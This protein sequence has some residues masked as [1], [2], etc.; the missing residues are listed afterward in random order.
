MID[1]SWVFG[2]IIMG[3]FSVV[4]IALTIKGIGYLFPKK[5]KNIDKDKK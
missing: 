1:N 2:Y 3:C 5:N 4:A